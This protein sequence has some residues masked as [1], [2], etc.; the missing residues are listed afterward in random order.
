[1]IQ[2][3][4]KSPPQFPVPCSIGLNVSDVCATGTVVVVVVVVGGTVVV[5][6]VVV[7]LPLNLAI[8]VSLPTITLGRALSSPFPDEH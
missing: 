3:G 6:Y 1:M 8:S 5:V 2:Q 7:V 4:G